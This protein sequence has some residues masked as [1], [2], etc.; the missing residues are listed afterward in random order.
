M[1]SKTAEV[2]ALKP[3]DVHQSLWRLLANAA[4]KL[5]DRE[6]LVALSNNPNKASIRWT[7]Q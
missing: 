2:A 1:L 3:G 6:A 4:G 5:G 7:Y